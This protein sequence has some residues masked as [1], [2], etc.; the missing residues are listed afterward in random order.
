MMTA[1]QRLDAHAVRYALWLL[2]REHA[3]QCNTVTVSTP[4]V[5][6]GLTNPGGNSTQA[7]VAKPTPFGSLTYPSPSAAVTAGSN[8][9][10]SAGDGVVRWGSEG[11]EASSGLK[12]TFFGVGSD[13]TTGNA[14]VYAWE[15]SVVGGVVAG[16]RLWV[17]TLL[18]AFSFELDSGMPGV[19][20][21][22]VPATNYFATSITLSTGNTGIS[23]EVIS[24]GHGQD[25]AH[26]VID[27][28]GARYIEV[29]YGTGSSATSLNGIWKRM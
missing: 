1:L 26:A 11:S 29:R 3:I 19:A 18:A 17:P 12:L 10:V 14:N 22:L 28:K 13:T 25:I 6:F 24:P 20:N 5:A 4:S 21:T 2:E 15:E 27:T 8:G 7:T 9:V 23:V 16:Q